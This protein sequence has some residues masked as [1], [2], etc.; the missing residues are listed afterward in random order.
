MARRPRHW[1]F[2]DPPQQILATGC[3][4]MPNLLRNIPFS[5][6]LLAAVADF[7]CGDEEWERPLAAW[8]Q[9]AANVKDGALYEMRRRREKLEV[10]L[11]VNGAGDLVGYSSL[12]ESNWQWPT[13][14]DPHGVAR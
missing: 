5:E 2:T 6:Q 4:T 3:R 11:H 13:A 14:D 1:H 10:W 7:E 8:I 9:A 12:G